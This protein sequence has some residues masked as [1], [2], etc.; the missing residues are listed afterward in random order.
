[1]RAHGRPQTIAPWLLAA[2]VAAR[3]VRR[4]RGLRARAAVDAVAGRRGAGRAPP[5][6]RARRP[7]AG[8]ALRERRAPLPSRAPATR[9]HAGLPPLLS[10]HRARL[11]GRSRRR[12]R[13]RDPLRHGPGPLPRRG[14]AQPRRAG[15]RDEGGPAEDPA[16]ARRLDPDPPRPRPRGLREGDAEELRRHAA[17][18]H[19]PRPGRRPHVLVGPGLGE[20]RRAPAAARRSSSPA[21]SSKGS[22]RPAR[23]SRPSWPASRRQDGVVRSRLSWEGGDL[24]FTRDPRDPRRLV[25]F[26]GSF[27]KP[28]WAETLT[29]RRVRVRPRPGVR[30]RPR[31]RSRRPGAPRRL[32][33]LVPAAGGHGARRRAGLRRSRRRASGPRRA[34]G[35]HRRRAGPRPSSSCATSSPLRRRTSTGPG[36]P[37]SGR[38]GSRP[39]GSSPSTR[40]CP[41][42]CDRWWRGC[43]PRAGTASRRR[44]SCA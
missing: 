21:G 33:R 19:A 10:P 39:S 34:P 1:M 4:R 23:R 44:T 5:G 40:R 16:S 14:H 29:P 43:A 24:Q 20:G 18:G 13:H 22:R 8:G 9:A 42:A 35:A 17:P 3:A 41:S 26:Y 27:A 36:R 32:L 30:R 37:S 7:G 12:P 11:P 28:Y 6:V 38:A 31:G 15:R 25:L 2:A